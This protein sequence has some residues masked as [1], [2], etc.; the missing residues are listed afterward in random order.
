MPRIFISYRRQ[1]SQ[2]AAGRLADNLKDHFGTA[3]IFRD[4]ETIEPGS[5]F[6]E[7]LIAALNSCAV[8]IAIIGPRW[9]S[10][11]DK[12]GQRRLDDPKDLTRQ[13]IEIALSR[14]IRVIPVIVDGATIFDVDDLP[15]E[16][17][18][19]AKRQAYELTDKRWNQDVTQLITTIDQILRINPREPTADRKTNR[20]KKLKVIV[21]T[22]LLLS[23][24]GTWAWF[25]WPSTRQIA[26]VDSERSQ[27]ILAKWD[28]ELVSLINNLRRKTGAYAWAHNEDGS[29][30]WTSA[31]CLSAL[32]LSQNSIPDHESLKE[33]F[34]YLRSS[35]GD[36]GWA[37]RVK[38]KPSI[39]ASA[40][41][42]LA[43]VMALLHVTSWSVDERAKMLDELTI[44]YREV[45][46]R[47]SEQGG[48]SSFQTSYNSHHA[49]APYATDLSLMFLLQLKHS[50]LLPKEHTEL[51]Q[52][53]RKG[54]NWILREYV[55]GITG[56]EESKDEGLQRELTT[57][58][59]ALITMAKQYGFSSFETDK[60]YREARR[61]WIETTW[62][63]S[64]ERSILEFSR[65][66]QMQ[67]VYDANGKYIDSHE[68]S[69]SLMWYPWT[70]LLASYLKDDQD[71]IEDERKKAWSIVDTL[72]A[73]LQILVDGV[74]SGPSYRPSETL[75]VLGMIRTAR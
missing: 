13:E 14:N 75:F 23:G 31:Q 16:L 51:E 27:T 56:W 57:L 26:I 58:H 72:E 74:R 36:G 48:W 42:G 15:P 30:A 40:W 6:T 1:D 35:R 43:Y 8:L 2:S 22:S 70:L 18:P 9:L 45:I 41:V 25:Y 49:F 5:D 28:H 20:L 59:L 29:D 19:L 69:A 63:F 3:Q 21:A 10:A 44:I 53:I 39:E 33:S 60:V 52:R 50:N 46:G 54:L 66:R 12:K 32:L 7:S 71:L 61:A 55:S 17:K 24:I 34:D 38:G 64:G 47:Q 73:K 11:T 37:V 4:I 67:G 65:I 68:H 62:K